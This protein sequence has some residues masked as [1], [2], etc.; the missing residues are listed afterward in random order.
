MMRELNDKKRFQVIFLAILFLVVLPGMGM[1]KNAVIQKIYIRE[2]PLS[3][4]FDMTRKVPV[5]VIQIENREVLVALKNATLA[6][7]L[8]VV[9]RN[10]PA[11]REVN[12]ESL[13]GGVVAVVVVG[14]SPYGSIK[15]EFSKSG[16]HFLVELGK[17]A[18][19]P[20]APK[21]AMA[22]SIKPDPPTVPP[23]SKKTIPV[24]AKP[25]AKPAVVQTP[26]PAETAKDVPMPLPEFPAMPTPKKDEKSVKIST[27]PTYVPP[28]REKSEFKGD[29]SDLYR[30]VGK[31]QCESEQIDNAILLMK[32]E[33]YK[34]AFELLE[35]YVFQENFTC[36][37]EVFYLRAYSYYQSLAENDFAR[38]IK[39]EQMFQEA[40][41]L[42]PKSEYL[43][44]G[45]TAIGLIHTDLKNISASEGYF[46][47]VMQGYG[48]YTG[49]PEVL[50][51]LARIYDEKGYTDKALRYYRQVFEAALENS[52]IP[53]AG[54]GYGK[55]LFKKQQ[56]FN[57]LTIFNYVVKLDVR[58]I[59]ESPDLLLHIANAN[60]ELS[61]SKAARDNF[62]RVMNLFPDL[63]ERDVI[64]S[65]VGD[66]YGMEDR[67]KKA[68]KIYE[69]VR[70]KFP[71]TQGFINASIGL[72]RYLKTDEE[73]I[74]I[75]EM[76]KLRFPEN[77][78]ARIAMMRLAEIYQKKGEYDKCIK[79]IEDL[80]STHP[81]GLRYEAVKLMQRAYEALF[82]QQLKDDGYTQVLHRYELEY[83]KIDKMDSRDIEFSVGKAYLRGNLY[84]QAF[85]H[86]LKAYKQ[87]KRSERSPE[88]LYTLGVAMD[89][90]GRDDDALKLFGA[91]SKRFLED[92]SRVPALM[93]MGNIY[94]EK[95]KFQSAS[96]SYKTAYAGSK[97]HLQKGHILLMHSRVFEIQSDLKTAAGLRDR[98]V[99][100]FAAAPGKNYEILT[101][102]YKSL[103]NT[104]ISLKS[105]V[106]A[107]DAFSKALQFSEGDR[108]KANLGFLL[109]DA[110]QKG[111]IL[112]KAKAAFEEVATAYDSVWARMARQRLDNLELAETV[113]NS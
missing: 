69:L 34:E 101:D 17:Q 32:K 51:H 83:I 99:K 53:D 112:T 20:R 81:R 22:P 102:A 107:A 23:S 111:N 14:R 68:I 21:T 92:K 98:A 25:E 109:G 16:T 7:D 54:I 26:A 41:V 105:Y 110:Y 28:Q 30:L 8:Q 5:K 44:F 13:H 59:Y 85:N 65:K 84:E 36:L 49:M 79:E 67:P 100:D 77:T 88:L 86:L 80:L 11:I 103:G 70:E 33:L 50:F 39:A 61:L 71:D 10:H 94:L 29:I 52:Y 78:Y 19:K 24:P 3:V 63:Q 62:I 15:S 106:R 75:Y 64:L 73:K 12:I 40:L 37:E 82:K 56:Y 46:N 1:A 4:S 18:A 35:Q 108:A 2:N 89:E 113:K 38:L 93:R 9:G 104:Y 95:K 60:F 45:Y 58:K 42:Y 76:V 57:S 66:T 74:E 96:S 90:S 91:L 31:R 55:A 6:K 27:P 47:I 72:A 43:P 48:E 87:Y 97:D